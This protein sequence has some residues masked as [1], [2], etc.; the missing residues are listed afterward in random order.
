M[1]SLLGTSVASNYLKI[2]SPGATAP[3]TQFGTRVLRV[4]KVT[5]S[6]GTKPDLTKGSDGSTGNYTDYGSFY[7][8]AIRAIQTEA[9]LYYVSIP[10]ATAFTIMISDDTVDDGTS[11]AVSSPTYSAIQTY[12]AN[13]LAG[14][15][16][17]NATAAISAVVLTPGTTI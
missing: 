1:P 16:S 15:P 6:G 7:S 9:E 4:L 10:T 2:G 5:I 12:I 13:A 14:F 11:V 8:L 3:L 17:S